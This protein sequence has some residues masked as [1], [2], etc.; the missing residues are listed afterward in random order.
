MMQGVLDSKLL[1]GFPILPL[2]LPLKLKSILFFLFPKVNCHRD[3]INCLLDNGANVNKLN[4]EGLSVLAAC[5][6]LFYTKHTWKDNI[7]ENIPH[8]NLFNCIQE[9]GQKGI[10]IHRNYRQSASV[11]DAKMETNSESGEVDVNSDD[12]FVANCT[13]NEN[14]QGESNDQ[15]T[16]KIIEFN[17]RKSGNKDESGHELENNLSNNLKSKLDL[18]KNGFMKDFQK[19]GMEII[20]DSSVENVLDSGMLT[21]NSNASV[22][23]E[24][25]GDKTSKLNIMNP[26]LFSMMSAVSSTR[27]LTESGDD[28]R[29]E[30]SMEQNKQVLLA[31]QR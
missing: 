6:V 12:E 5:H 24:N 2:H 13:E 7:A 30:N 4:D 18:K 9:D 31:V 17:D 21:P 27:Q 14:N 19:Q 25:V 23:H 1:G 11:E 8:E 16:Y 26:S 15:R 29:S 28:L 20:I 3:V 22:T 10:Y